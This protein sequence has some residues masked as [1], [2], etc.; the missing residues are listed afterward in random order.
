MI[1]TVTVR[2]SS[3]AMAGGEEGRVKVGRR[4]SQIV[5]SPFAVPA[6]AQNKGIVVPSS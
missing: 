6:I 1:T 5:R 2:C 3:A 4:P